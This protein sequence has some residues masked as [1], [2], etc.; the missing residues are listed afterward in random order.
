MS[1]K[2][3]RHVERVAQCLQRQHVAVSVKGA[4]DSAETKW[5]AGLYC[6]PQG[7]GVTPLKNTKHRAC[8]ELGRKGYRVLPVAEGYWYFNAVFIC[9]VGVEGFE[10]ELMHA[11]LPSA[12]VGVRLRGHMND[13]G[14][15]DS[16]L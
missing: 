9:A 12:N 8:V 16:S 6:Q 13:V 14:S 1:G 15:S 5:R 2:I 11:A 10:L 7:L 4:H 3:D